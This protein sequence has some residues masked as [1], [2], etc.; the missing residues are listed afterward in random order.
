MISK[1]STKNLIFK[2]LTKNTLDVMIRANILHETMYIEKNTIVN[3]FW[4]RSDFKDHISLLYKYLLCNHRIKF[5]F[6][7]II[8]IIIK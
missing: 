4:I 3:I 8:I 7:R 2:V 6:L 5:L 1:R